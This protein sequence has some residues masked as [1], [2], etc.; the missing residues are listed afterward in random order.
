M[1]SLQHIGN[2]GYSV[3]CQFN[4]QLDTPYVSCRLRFL[5]WCPVDTSVKVL[6]IYSHTEQFSG[7]PDIKL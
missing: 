3:E 5:R 1:G 7:L 4:L 6:F 2:L